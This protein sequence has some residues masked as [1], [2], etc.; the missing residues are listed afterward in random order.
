MLNKI[1]QIGLEQFEGD[2]QLAGEFV[3]GF[4][5]RALSLP[6]ITMPAA[7]SLSHHMLGEAAGGLASAVGKGIGATAVG[8]GVAGLGAAANM[9]SRSGLHTKFLAA[10]ETAVQKNVVLRQAEPEK[11]HQYAETVFKFAPN[12]ATDPN[13][14]S[15]ILANAIHGDGIDPMTIRTLSDLEGRYAENQSSTFSPKK[16]V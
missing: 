8:L 2:Q 1:A 6:T 7:G 10:L 14:L 4:V 12:V 9:V 5:K 3:K 16:Y 15:S 13:L 11:V